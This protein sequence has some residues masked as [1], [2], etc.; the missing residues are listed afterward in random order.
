M[1]DEPYLRRPKSSNRTNLKLAL[2]ILLL[3]F[4]SYTIG[5]TYKAYKQQK[6]RSDVKAHKAIVAAIVAA[7][8]YLAKKLVVMFKKKIMDRIIKKFF[9]KLLEELKENIIDNAMKKVKNFFKKGFKEMLKEATKE[10]AKRA[11]GMAADKAQEYME[12]IPGRVQ[13]SLVEGF[14][15]GAEDYANYK[16][17]KL[18]FP[19]ELKIMLEAEMDWSLENIITLWVMQIKPSRKYDGPAITGSDAVDIAITDLMSYLGIEGPFVKLMEIREI[20]NENMDNIITDGIRKTMNMNP[21]YKF[22]GG[23]LGTGMKYAG[24]LFGNKWLEMAG[25]DVF[26]YT[27]NFGDNFFRDFKKGMDIVGG[28]VGKYAAEG[29]MKYMEITSNEEYKRYEK[30]FNDFLEKNSLGIDEFMKK[31]NFTYRTMRFVYKNLYIGGRYLFERKEEIQKKVEELMDEYI[32]DPLK[33][34]AKEVSELP[35]KAGK[36]FD[37]GMSLLEQM[38]K[39]RKALFRQLKKDVQ[40]Q[41]QKAAEDAVK[42]GEDGLN[43][44]YDGAKAGVDAAKKAG[45]AVT[46]GVEELFKAGEAFKDASAEEKAKMVGEVFKNGAEF[47]DEAVFSVAFEEYLGPGFDGF[48]NA[49]EA[50]GE[51]ISKGF[52][53]ASTFVNDAAKDAAEAA[54]GAFNDGVEFADKIRK[55]PIGSAKK[56]FDKTKKAIE[57]SAEFVSETATESWDWSKNASEDAYDWSKN[58]GKDATEWTK[59]AAGDTSEWAKEAAKD[60]YEWGLNAGDDSIKWTGTAVD[61]TFD[62]SSN[63]AS[64]AAKWTEGAVKDAGKGIKKGFKFVGDNLANPDRSAKFAADTASDCFN[65]SVDW[66]GGAFDDVGEFLDDSLKSFM[67]AGESVIEFFGEEIAPRAERVYRFFFTGW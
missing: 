61:D 20:I 58:A 46:K 32:G 12:S 48:V 30:D 26:K 49:A 47:M 50:A 23:I 15:K 37:D 40:K 4:A 10:A 60:S 38:K 64:D 59:G 27:R 18:V 57:D 51:A 5:S 17:K 19:R 66:V 33:D 55:D 34:L 62:W 41:A 63:A 65:S 9:K 6:A 35:D 54:V 67:N 1:F 13:G 52:G 8:K 45:E 28:E 42:L 2:G 14:H 39:N 53:I 25:D 24:K 3:Y 44:A 7:L 16:G 36:G 29:M 56:A 11:A 43:A 21:L 31:W 22:G